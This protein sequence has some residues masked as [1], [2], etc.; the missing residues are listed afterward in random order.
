M[1]RERLDFFGSEERGRGEGEVN[2]NSSFSI[3][4]K[5]ILSLRRKDNIG[6]TLSLS[7]HFETFKNF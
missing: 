7:F 3:L 2:E 1:P 5:G 4:R 6:K